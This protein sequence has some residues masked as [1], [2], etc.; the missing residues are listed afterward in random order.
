MI[1]SLV[2][3]AKVLSIAAFFA[4]KYHERHQWNELIEKGIISTPNKRK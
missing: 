4:G 2:I 1:V 3:L